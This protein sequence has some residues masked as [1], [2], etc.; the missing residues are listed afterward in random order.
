[1]FLPR[2]P[3]LTPG[4]FCSFSNGSGEQSLLRVSNHRPNRSLLGALG[5]SKQGSL[6]NP[7]YCQRVSR[8]KCFTLGW[9]E[10]IFKKSTTPKLSATR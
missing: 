1:M 5:F 4:Y 10:R 3:I 9:D 2:A 8:L 7:R 6:T